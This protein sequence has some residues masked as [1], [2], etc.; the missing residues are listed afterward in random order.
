MPSNREASRLALLYGIGVYSS[1]QGGLR[2]YMDEIIIGGIL[3][4]MFLALPLS[5]SAI[6][7]AKHPEHQSTMKHVRR[8]YH[9]IRGHAEGR[10]ISLSRPGE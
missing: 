10:R 6:Q 4:T 1:V 7:G 2:G 5:A 8:A 3:V 9:W